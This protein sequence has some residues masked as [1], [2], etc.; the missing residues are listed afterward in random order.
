MLLTP[1]QNHKNLAKHFSVPNLF[2]KREDLHPYTSH[3]GRAIPFMIEHHIKKDN[4]QEFTISSTGNAALAAI[5]FAQNYN[6]QNTK[7][8]ITLTVYVGKKIPEKKYAR[9][10]QE[11]TDPHIQLFQTER[12]K[13][14]AFQKGKEDGITFLRQST[15]PV[16]LT[17]YNSL[18]EE[19]NNIQNLG[20]IFIATSSGTTAQALGEWFLKKQKDV[21][22]HIVQT[23]TCNPIAKMFDTNYVQTPMSLATC[24]GDVVVHRKAN[25]A[26]IIKKT[27]GFGWVVDDTIITEAQQLLSKNNIKTTPN[28]ALSVAGL[29]KAKKQGWET[30]KSVVCIIS[31][32]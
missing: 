28:G 10:M 14:T 23:T 12:P 11:I 20:A 4:I 24:I 25:V 26:D 5:I 31:G 30:K 7:T 29:I 22:I 8:P 16:A 3:K 13:Q 6:T 27:E 19:L 21:Q 2:I 32:E 9:L 18:A 17:G 1:Q 15:N